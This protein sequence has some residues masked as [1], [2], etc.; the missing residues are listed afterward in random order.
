ML[1]RS[2]NWMYKKPFS[3]NFSTIHIFLKWA[4]HSLFF[5][6]FRSFQTNNTI[7]TTNQCEKCPN[8]HLVYSAGIQTFWTESSTITTRPLGFPP[9][10]IHILRMNSHE[11]H[12]YA[13]VEGCGAKIGKF[14]ILLTWNL[15]LSQDGCMRQ[16]K[17]VWIILLHDIFSFPR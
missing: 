11:L 3:Y 8:V 7:F 9:N 15:T 1:N 2:A 14:S 10:T 6:Y 4:N 16:M 5:V 13:M 17:H 12:A